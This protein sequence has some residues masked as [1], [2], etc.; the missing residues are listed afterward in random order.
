MQIAAE[1]NDKC[2]IQIDSNVSKIVF[3]NNEA[4]RAGSSLYASQYTHVISTTIM[5]YLKPSTETMKHIMRSTSILQ[6][7][8]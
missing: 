4:R 6:T 8:N 5:K 2:V 3:T 7:P 1:S